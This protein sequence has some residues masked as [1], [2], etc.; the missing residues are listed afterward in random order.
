[1]VTQTAHG[2]SMTACD[3]ENSARCPVGHSRV[4]TLAPSLG[5]GVLGVAGVVGVVGVLGRR[6]EDLGGGLFPVRSS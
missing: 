5:Q 6:A 1:M 4:S 3:Y 2:D